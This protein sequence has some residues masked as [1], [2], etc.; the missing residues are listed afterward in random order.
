MGHGT[1]IDSRDGG[2]PAPFMLDVGIAS[3]A[4]IAEFWGLGTAARAASRAAPRAAGRPAAPA[5]G[6]DVGGVIAD[7]LRAAGM[8]K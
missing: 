2:T 7:A 1:P 3:S 6:F 5:R 4:R 8:M